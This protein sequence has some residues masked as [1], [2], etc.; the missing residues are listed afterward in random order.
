MHGDAV[1]ES[2]AR[3]NES[4]QNGG[5]EN[6]ALDAPFPVANVDLT[7]VDAA[8][9]VWPVGTSVELGADDDAGIVDL[10]S[11]TDV[12]V[13]LEA[14][15]APYR[16]A[17]LVSDDVEILEAR[18]L[19]AAVYLESGYVAEEDLAPDGTIGSRKDPWPIAS[20]YFAVVRD[21]IVAATARQISLVDPGEL[22]ALRLDGLREV[23]VAKVLDLPSNAVVEISGLAARRDAPGT[24]VTALY[25][26]MWRESLRRG[27]QV[28]MMAVDRRL[29]LNLRRVFA[30]S[31]LQPI[32]PVQ[33]H[34]GSA[35]VPAVLW[36]AEMPP[37]Q[38]RMAASARDRKDLSAL[39]PMLFPPGVGAPLG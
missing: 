2:R 22:P 9:D 16:V 37:E 23:E 17:R 26:R 5:D 6:N 29:Y 13:E 10:R 36:C 35:V 18:R 31:A 24:D 20:T 33:E 8:A 1:P 32:G 25:S 27:H 7:V 15:L 14:A 30:G 34:L 39:L 21:G 19:H 38:R 4:A 12:D 28:W 11:A 3:S